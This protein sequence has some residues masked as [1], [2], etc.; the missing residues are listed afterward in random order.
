MPITK[1]Y[2]YKKNTVKDII[3]EYVLE[4]KFKTLLLLWIQSKIKH[5]GSNFMFKTHFTY[6]SKMIDQHTNIRKGSKENRIL[7]YYPQIHN[8]QFDFGIFINK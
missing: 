6:V 7:Y 1:K 5:L 2:L 3:L 4:Q 8:M